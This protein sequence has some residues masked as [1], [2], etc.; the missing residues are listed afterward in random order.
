MCLWIPLFLD[1]FQSLQQMFSYFAFVLFLCVT[2]D[3]NTLISLKN[4]HFMTLEFK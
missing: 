1:I 2:I 4:N 3:Q